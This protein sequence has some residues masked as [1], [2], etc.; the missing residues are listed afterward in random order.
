LSAEGSA[1]KGAAPEVKLPEAGRNAAG[2]ASR[3]AKLGTS[4]AANAPAPK[5]AS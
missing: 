4:S 3:T 5:T 1:K 2:F